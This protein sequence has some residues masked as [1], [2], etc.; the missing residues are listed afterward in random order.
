MVEKLDPNFSS[1]FQVFDL[2]LTPLKV[3]LVS[4]QIQPR[5]S[6]DISSFF[7]LVSQL[8]ASTASL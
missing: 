2:A 5:S 1:Y 4:D 3:Q 7:R 6:L 8:L